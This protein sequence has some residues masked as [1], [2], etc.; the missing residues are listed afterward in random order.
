MKRYFNLYLYLGAAFLLL[1]CQQTEPKKK[2]SA[3][4]DFYEQSEMA[5]IMDDMYDFLKENRKRVQ[6]SE[7]LETLP[8]YFEEIH[9]AKMADD[10]TRDPFFNSFSE[11]FLANMKALHTSDNVD[12]T[13]LFNNA[14]NS[15]IA[16]HT[17]GAA[18]MGPIPRISKLLIK[19]E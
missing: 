14:V 6:A 2:E 13:I 4:Q 10:Y 3:F 12:K 16:C 9:T 7:T 19:T 11:A 8:E 17:S 1:S 5:V 18:C 15:C